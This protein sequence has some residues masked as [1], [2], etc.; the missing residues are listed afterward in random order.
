MNIKMLFESF[1]NND[2]ARTMAICEKE[3]V[4]AKDIMRTQNA[5]IDKLK[6][7]VSEAKKTIKDRDETIKRLHITGTGSWD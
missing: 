2:D 4:I 6:A 5:L 3:L 7:I 1:V